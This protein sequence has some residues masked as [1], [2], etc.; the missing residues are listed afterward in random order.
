MRI[1][2]LQLAPGQKTP[3]DCRAHVKSLVEEKVPHDV[4]LVVL[5]ELW[6][7]G[8][9]RQ[10]VM[11]GVEMLQ[12]P[13]N[14]LL[15][16]LARE[17]GI[18]IVGGSLPIKTPQGIHNFCAV[19][20]PGGYMGG[21]AKVH[22]FG[23]LG[24]KEWCIPGRNLYLFSTAYGK[25]GVMICYDLRFPE[26]ARLLAKAG[27]LVIF[28]PAA[29]PDARIEQWELLLRA[30]AVENQVFIAGVNKA[31]R[32]GSL[33]FPGRSLVVAPDGKVLA[34]GSNDEDIIL[35]EID[36]KLIDQVRS[37][38]P[39]WCDLSPWAYRLPEEDREVLS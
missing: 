31:G 20:G 25:M 22:P 10:N 24:E 39:C 1:A 23:P 16:G 3:E 21:Y 32:E 34:A 14:A 35:C 38:I 26:V 36:F 28:V 4:D 33:I 15:A 2:L 8:H 7:T 13:T 18:Y 19:H 37:A 11:R 9:L 6:T 5:P 27:A 17:R 12:G 30:R 29:F